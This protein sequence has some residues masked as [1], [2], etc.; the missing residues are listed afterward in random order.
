MVAQAP[1]SDD[2][3]STLARDWA[4]QVD[5]GTEDEPA[6]TYVRGLSQFAKQTSLTMQDDSDIDSGGYS[7]QIPTGQEL[8]FQGEGMRKGHKA[9]GTFVEDPGQKW[10]RD[11]GKRMGAANF[12]RARCWRTDGVQE[13]Y[14]SRFSVNWEDAAGGREDLDSF[15]FTMMSRG[16]PREIAPVETDDAPSVYVDEAV[17]APAD[18]GAA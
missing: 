9:E 6:W 11:H 18:G 2:L 15:S 5:T 17:D 1:F 3:E 16:M 12:V 14:E 4:V 8:T 7:S 13:G 10:L